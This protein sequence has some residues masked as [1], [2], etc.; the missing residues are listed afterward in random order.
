LGENIEKLFK[1]FA[2][3]GKHEPIEIPK[4]NTSSLIKQ[5]I[6]LAKMI[7]SK[8]VK[9]VMSVLIIGGTTY[10]F[11]DNISNYLFLPGP[12]TLGGWKKKE[13]KNWPFI[14]KR[15]VLLFFFSFL[16]FS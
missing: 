9:V 7:S 10:Y 11:Y 2:E 1:R 15:P 16:F 8:R 4:G 6:A 13:K 14:S 5:S 3:L 12:R